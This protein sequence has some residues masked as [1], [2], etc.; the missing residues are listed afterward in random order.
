MERESRKEKIQDS[1]GSYNIIR[2]RLLDS[3]EELKGKLEKL[4]QKR[5]EIFGQIKKGL[6]RSEAIVT[7]NNCIP[8]DIVSIGKKI[9]LGY[10]VRIGMKAETRISDVFSIY[11]YQEGG[12]V[13]E[14]YSLL[15]DNSFLEDFRELFTYYKE[16]FFAKFY[17]KDNI[18]HMIFQNGSNVYDIKS[19]KWFIREDNTLEYLGNRYVHEISYPPQQELEWIET[20]REDQ[21]AGLYP[22]I[23]I[24][25]RLF[26]E[27]IG[28]T[29][30]LKVENN[31][32]TGEGIYEEEVENKDQKLDDAQIYYSIVGNLILLKIKP[33]QE[34]DFRYIVFN[35]KTREVQRVDSIGKAVVLLPEDHGIAFPDG[36]FLQTGVF[37]RFE[38]NYQDIVFQNRKVS[39]NGEDYQYIFYDLK[40]GEYYILNYNI[41]HQDV[42]TPIHCN[43]YTRF[44]NGEMIVFKADDE[45]KRSHTLQIWQTS[46]GDIAATGKSGKKDGL[47][48]NL[49]NKEIVRFLADCYSLYNLAKKDDS[50]YG[51]YIDIVRDTE[52]IIANY[53]WTGEE[54]VFKIRESLLKLKEAGEAAIK[55]YDKIMRIRKD[56]QR[57]YGQVKKRVEDLTKALTYTAFESIND[58]V[59]Y[60]V[61]IRKLRGEI[62][63]L[64]DLE[65]IDPGQVEELSI[66]IKEKNDKLSG[67]CIEFLLRD[68]SL[69]PYIEMVRE[70]EA[71]LPEVEKV[72][73]G[74]AIN[75]RIVELSGEL[76]LLIEIIN[77]L[78]IDDSTKASGILDKIS[79]LFANLN[80]CK[81]LLKNR[82]DNLNIR[83]METEF[84]SRMNLLTH[85][86]S[87]YL[88]L[89]L[90]VEKN[91]EYMSKIIIQLDELESKFSD[92]DDFIVKISEKREE[93]ISGFE[94]N[95]QQLLE[96][97]NRKIDALADAADRIFKSIINRVRSFEK[98]REINEFFST[99]PM[100][101]KLRDIADQ[102][103]EF[104][105]STKADDIE[106]RLKSLKES[107]IKELK[108]KRELFL[109]ENTI[110]LGQHQF[111]VNNQEP[112]LTLLRKADGFYFHI[113][114]TDFWEKTEEADFLEFRAVWDQEIISENEDVYRGE[115]LAYSIFKQYQENG[116]LESLYNADQQGLEKVIQEYIQGHSNEYYVRGIHDQD[117]QKILRELVELYLEMDLASY[118]PG[119]RAAAVLFW[120]TGIPEEAKARLAKRLKALKLLSRH[121][122][123]KLFTAFLPGLSREIRIFIENNPWIKYG[124]CDK[125]AEYLAREISQN[126]NYVLSME[127]A[128]LYEDFQ[129]FLVSTSGRQD[130]KESLEKLGDDLEGKYLLAKEWLEAY[131]YEKELSFN[132][133]AFEVLSILILDDFEKR[134]LINRKAE[135][136]IEK[137]LGDHNLIND[138]SYKTNLIEFLDKLDNFK[139]NIVPLFKR[140]QELKF[141]KIREMKKR[142]NFDDLK[143]VVLT[144]FVRNKL[145]DQVYLPLI[146]DNLA[147]QIGAAGRSKRTDNMGMLLLVSP[148]GYGKTT[149]MEYIASRLNMIMVKINCPAI[150]YEISSLDPAEATNAGAREE[151]TKL[152]FAF[153]IGNN[154]MLYLDD[155][156]HSSPEFLQKFISLCDGQRKIEGVYKGVSRTYQFRG[157]KFCVVMAGNPYTE[158]GEKFMIPDMLANRADVYNLGDMARENEEAFKLSYLENAVTSNKYLNN[159]YLKNQDDIYKLIQ[160]ALTGDRESVELEG[161]YS[162]EEI[163]ECLSILKS[164]ARIRDVIMKVNSEY[165][166]SSSQ[167]D[168]FR[169]EPPFKLQ[170]SYRNMNK[171]VEKVVPVMNEEEIDM[172]IENSYI[173]DAQTLAAHAEAS[174]LKFYEITNK[175]SPEKEKRWNE[176]KRIY[177]NRKFEKEGQRVVQVIK[178]LNNIG[179]NLKEISNNLRDG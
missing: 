163:E 79:L 155:I 138:G 171:I 29:L 9:I 113:S 158:S 75:D 175:M 160:I 57:Q 18:I 111:L 70:I 94:L 8:R 12:F 115:F 102:L 52:N 61:E 103:I 27:T 118:N 2:N 124:D 108:D 20:T 15:A 39:S 121:S 37:R 144:S 63:E 122:R 46:F 13:R 178:E 168:E 143:P 109:D 152:N 72:S 19:F 30:T 173:N 126:E 81:S 130:F 112:E 150:G 84:Y 82:L 104:G 159:I 140:F 177:L 135:I 1:S 22:H 86:V 68:E 54:E 6:I 41:V 32:D 17:K 139:E 66:R 97:K 67:D 26:V 132:D 114:G 50:Y 157:K 96:K 101:E 99:S 88:E 49:G 4:D 117:S 73:D 156:Q 35:E 123:K 83:E 128:K 64:R 162:E 40:K 129:D 172:L 154:V 89:A 11:T 74:N 100:I 31:T 87:N 58:Y 105:D 3:A 60:L 137:L 110:R 145:I 127:G 134:R 80:Q 43:G 33:Y 51:L 98:E 36:I 91:E 167:N 169:T 44:D 106:N 179:Q 21:V 136:N 141:D 14:D 24:E 107:S 176:I 170:G 166:Y 93:I 10:N 48:Y 147:K 151:L 116:S 78:R 34:K 131:F 95:K 76:E 71:C 119:I 45:P 165:I 53:F 16:S 62:A 85:T 120:E 65:F 7:E 55:E 59:K 133:Y 149:L 153:E 28:G 125:A 174:L 77:S 161:A 148:P 25:D 47:L 42:E 90:T 23:S 56:N 69:T 92:F 38:V 142:I 164:C 5:V 146:G